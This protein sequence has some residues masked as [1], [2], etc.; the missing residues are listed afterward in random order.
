MQAMSA[1]EEELLQLHADQRWPPGPAIADF[2]R[3]LSPPSELRSLWRPTTEGTGFREPVVNAP[4][5]ASLASLC[6]VPLDKTTV[7]QIRRL[8]DFDQEWFDTAYD[9][10]MKIG[11]GILLEHGRELLE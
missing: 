6:A 10:S 3:I 7:Y 1:A 2:H 8:R 11:M 9:N 5:A 4:I